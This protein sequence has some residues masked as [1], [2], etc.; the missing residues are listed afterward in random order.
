MG[1]MDQRIDNHQPGR[2]GAGVRHPRLHRL[3]VSALG[4][5]H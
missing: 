3:D 1:L 2:A 4:D 5:Q